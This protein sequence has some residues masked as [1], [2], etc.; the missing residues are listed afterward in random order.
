MSRYLEHDWYPDPLPANVQL[1]ER[2]W[3]Y[4]TYAFRHYQSRKVPGVT[5]GNNTGLYNSTFFDLGPD[6]EV[7]I[8]NYCTVVGAI[9][10]TNAR[11]VIEDYVLIAHDVVL[12]DRPTAIPCWDQDKRLRRDEIR[13]STGDVNRECIFIGEN[14][15]I[16]TRA[17]LLSGARIGQGSIVG[18]GA[19][20]DFVVPPYSIV[21]GNPACIVG[22][23]RQRP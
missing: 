9:F 22:Q 13:N 2:T 23:V 5:V 15:W 3:L 11:V 6:G 21:A 19:V 7:T 12:A 17:I 4:S 18:A 20:V 16:A 10:C 14:A 8:G 1:G